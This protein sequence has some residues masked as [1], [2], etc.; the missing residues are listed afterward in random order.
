M[1]PWS[2][3][4]CVIIKR[5]SVIPWLPNHRLVESH[6]KQ[7]KIQC[8][9]THGDTVLMYTSTGTQQQEHFGCANRVSHTLA[10]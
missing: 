6:D 7:Q 9:L 8:H 3:G 5:H 10:V 1:N 4:L 2:T